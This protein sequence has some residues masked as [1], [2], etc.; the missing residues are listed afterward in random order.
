MCLRES[1]RK[2]ERFTLIEPPMLPEQPASPN[3]RVIL[4]FGLMLAIGGAVGSIALLETLDG[5]VRGRNDLSTLL[6]IPP[7]A[8]VPWVVTDHERVIHAKRRRIAAVG[9]FASIV[10][11]VMAAHFF[12]R[13]LDVLWQVALRRLG[14]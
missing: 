14:A 11:A 5:S 7:L 12:Y 4:A 10:L 1:E 3:R 2:G 6:K 13:P 9:V 8:V